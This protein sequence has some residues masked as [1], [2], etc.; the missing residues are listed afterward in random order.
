MDS[1]IV[2]PLGVCIASEFD[3]FA[4]DLTSITLD[5]MKCNSLAFSVAMLRVSIRDSNVNIQMSTTFGLVLGDSTIMNWIRAQ[6][7]SDKLTSSH[8]Y[9]NF[10]ASNYEPHYAAA[11]DGNEKNEKKE[12][13]KKNME[14]KEN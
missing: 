5:L 9:C 8:G 14:K 1:A 11:A 13:E 4:L 6:K 2:V 10:N 12:N 7:N 3:K